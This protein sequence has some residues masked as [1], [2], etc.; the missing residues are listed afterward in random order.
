MDLGHL[1]RA[2]EGAGIDVTDL[3]S[4]P[5]D[6]FAAWFAEVE[7]AGLFEPNAVVVATVDEHGVPAARNVLLKAFDAEGFVFYTNTRSAKGRALD[8]TGRAALLFSWVELRR[9]VHVRGTVTRVADAEADA[10]FASR[11]RGSQL[12]AWASPQ[13]EVVA[14]RADL[15][16]RF[17]AAVV[18][19]GGR[20]VTRPPH[21]TGY[22]VHPLEV[23]FWQGRP[24]RL[25]DRLR[26]TRDGGAWLVERLAP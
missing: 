16:A 12:G 1:R 3:R 26:F 13:S 18:A 23:E 24:D 5:I 2:Y 22:R 9:Q 15:D 20:E 17:E 4:D 25:H 7:Q 19:W 21:W 10:Y 14:S 8:A 6:Q 11:P